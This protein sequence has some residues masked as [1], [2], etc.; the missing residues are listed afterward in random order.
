MQITRIGIKSRS[1]NSSQ[2]GL[3]ILELIALNTENFSHR[4]IVEKIIQ[5]VVSRIAPSLLIGSSSNLE[6]HKS[7]K[8][9]QT[10]LSNLELLALEY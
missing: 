9:G 10:G 8:F 2:M 6:R 7:S 3:F 5:N 1:S 4:L